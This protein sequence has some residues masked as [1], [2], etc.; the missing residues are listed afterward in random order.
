MLR[1]QML[2]SER[3]C[4]LAADADIMSSPAVEAG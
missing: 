4:N 1:T 2:S 3:T